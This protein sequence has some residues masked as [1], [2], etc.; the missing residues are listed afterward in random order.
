VRDPDAAVLGDKTG[1]VL[2][3]HELAYVLGQMG[4]EESVRALEA[5]LRDTS[6]D[7]IVRH[8]AA[9]A[10]AA[11][12]KADSLP[13]LKEFCT[14]ASPEVAETC[15]IGVRS[16]EWQAGAGDKGVAERDAANPFASVDPAPPLAA[17]AAAGD[18]KA[19]EAAS[20]AVA[21]GATGG[22]LT[23]AELEAQLMD[24]SAPLFDRYRAMFTLRNAATHDADAVL[25]LCQGLKAKSALFRHEAAY[26]LGQVARPE[27]TAA[28]RES[29]EAETEHPMVRHEA[30]EALGAVATE[31]AE[32][33]L[34]ELKSS[35]CQIVRE[36]CEVALDAAEYFAEFAAST[37]SAV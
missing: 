14:D 12:G 33:I 25:A 2:F 5:V 21:A 11:I 24:E 16:L 10:I 3:R 28:L 15:E 31:E 29:L 4:V 8:E 26:V 7:A 13:L 18:A 35:D 22:D 36:S 34:H 27:S 30:A 37:K 32:A 19:S 23:V 9:E 6:D 17:L 1:S 20:T